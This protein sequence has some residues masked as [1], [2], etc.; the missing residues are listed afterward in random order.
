M[1]FKKKG[2]KQIVYK[3]NFIINFLKPF[4]RKSSKNKFN[5]IKISKFF[6]TLKKQN[7][8]ELKKQN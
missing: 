4:L 7:L 2:K 6:Q 1:F 8:E 3:N 5:I